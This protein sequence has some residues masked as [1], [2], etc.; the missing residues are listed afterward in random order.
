MSDSPHTT[1]RLGRAGQ[2]ARLNAVFSWF[3]QTSE[4]DAPGVASTAESVRLKTAS[5]NFATMLKQR[6][7]RSLT[8]F[9]FRTKQAR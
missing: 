8:P 1:T 9:S 4:A 5:S 3:L 7:Y 2:I 6:S